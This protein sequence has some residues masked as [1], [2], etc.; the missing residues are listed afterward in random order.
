MLHTLSFCQTIAATRGHSQRCFADTSSLALVP[1]PL[2]E[3][4]CTGLVR[5]LHVTRAP[6]ELG[7]VLREAGQE[8]PETLARFDLSVARKDPPSSSPSGSCMA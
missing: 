7:Q 8:I 1:H 3:Q 2:D 4:G 5:W 6:R